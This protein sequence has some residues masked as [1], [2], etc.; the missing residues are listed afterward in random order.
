MNE[1]DLASWEED[2]YLDMLEK[3]IEVTEM[4]LKGKEKEE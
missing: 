1:D 2:K 3:Q 4:I